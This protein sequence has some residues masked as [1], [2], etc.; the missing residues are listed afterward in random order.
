[1]APTP[2]AEQLAKN[3]KE[4]SVAEFFERNKHVLGFDSPTRALITGVKEAVDNALDACEEAQVLPEVNVSLAYLGDSREEFV[5]SVEDNGPGIVKRQIP[6]IF[7][8]LLYGSRFHA[9]RQSRGQQG[10]GIS[11]AVLY[12]QLTTGQHAKV[13]S[14]IGDGHPVY[15]CD[16]FID[17]KKN[18]PEIMNESLD[19]WEKPSGTRITVPMLGRYVKGR[20]S[21]YEYL[22]GTA[23]VNPHARITY[24]E[25]DG[26]HH[27][28]ERASDVMPRECVEIKPHPHGVEVGTV[29]KMT[30]GANNRYLSGFLQTEFSSMGSRT[31]T[32]VLKAA[33]LNKSD[34]PREMTLQQIRSLVEAFKK[35]KI[36]APPTDCLSPIGETLVKRGLKKETEEISPE[37]IISCMRQPAVHSGSPFQIEVG[38]VYG[39]SL[40]RD[41][42]VRILRFANRVPLIYQQG[43]CALTHSIEQI[44]W[45]RYGLDQRGGKGIPNGPAIFLVHIA[46]TNIPFTNESKEAVADIPDVVGEIKLALR[47]CARRLQQHLKKK[48]KRAKTK[49]KFEL[50]TKVLPEIASKSAG[51]L[52]KPVPNLDHV[53]TKI[54]D[55][56]WIDDEIRYEKV[57]KAQP[58]EEERKPVRQMTFDELPEDAADAVVSSSGWITVSSIKVQNYTQKPQGFTIHALIPPEATLG[59]A[60]PVPSKV[61]PKKISW[62]LPEIPSAKTLTIVFELAG[63]GKGDFDEN[64]IYT[65]GINPLCVIG[66]DN[67]EGG[68]TDVEVSVLGHQ[69]EEIAKEE[70]EDDLERAS[71]KGSKE[72]AT[73]GDE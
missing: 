44:D 64:E 48:E 3:Q 62:E 52:G 15:S 68:D 72:K 56:V 36:M 45:R 59:R 37:F 22:R 10:I 39:G 26:T 57:Q 19:H 46:S 7:G 47:D 31:V 14:K 34:N 50:I 33:G 38:M 17:T 63:L 69:E 55:I 30:K 29:I 70:L 40:P 8:K 1:M 28:F 24:T 9:I 61:T 42:Q 51:M 25:P 12:G 2:I 21:V 32:D 23:I 5:L 49:Q 20:Q 60:E 54:M 73:G 43:G 13:S 18:Y 65:E 53:I 11:A 71:E 27:V 6:S 4:I 41:G 35:V 16:I 58:V 67:W 66:A